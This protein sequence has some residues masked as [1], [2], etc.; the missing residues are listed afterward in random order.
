[1]TKKIIDEEEK[2]VIRRTL[3]DPSV[4]KEINEFSEFC[5]QIRKRPLDRKLEYYGYPLSQDKFPGYVINEI[6]GGVHFSLV[7]QAQDEGMIT[8]NDNG[9]WAIVG[10]EEGILRDNDGKIITE[11]NRT[12]H[13]FAHLMENIKLLREL[14]N[15]AGVN[16]ML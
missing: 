8:I 2:K 13:T 12:W 1:M 5:F 16:P 14:D 6:M 11:H 7:R 4:R 10:I 9:R 3:A 15:R